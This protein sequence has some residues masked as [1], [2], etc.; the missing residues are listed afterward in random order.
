MTIA[1]TYRGAS[2]CASAA[3]SAE[4]AAAVSPMCRRRGHDT[5]GLAGLGPVSEAR[6]MGINVVVV[7]GERMF[8]DALAARLAAEDDVEAVSVI[9]ARAICYGGASARHADVL[10]LDADL[11]DG[12]ATRVCQSVTAAGGSPRVIMLSSLPGPERIVAAVR[13]GAAAWVRKDESIT[14][15]LRVV[16]GVVC[17]ETWLPP[18][19]TGNVLQLLLKRRDGDKLL[20]VLTPRERQVL[21]LLAQGASRAEMAQR[22][23]LSA[24]TIRTHLQ[25]LMAKL[26][27]H[28]A[29]E[30]VALTR[31]MLDGSW[32]ALTR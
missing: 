3:G 27:V 17:G 28:S 12:A 11:S 8:A 6:G 23:H 10:L 30:A 5:R 21:A 22:L 18:S 2:Y 24:N 31:S 14:H 32:P 29:I 1:P 9:S 4:A 13:A 7:D 19:E 26:G 20:A 15:L 25:N 16:R